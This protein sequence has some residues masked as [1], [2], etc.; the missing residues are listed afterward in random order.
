MFFNLVSEAF[1]MGA[2]PQAAD[3]AAGG[4]VQGMLVQ[5]APLAI[6]FVIFYFLLI[7][8]QQKKAKE[9]KRMLESLKKG[10]KIVTAGGIHG[11][12][13]SVDPGTVIVKIAETVKIKVNRNAVTVRTPEDDIKAE[14]EENE[15]TEKAVE[16]VK[17][18]EEKTKK[19]AKK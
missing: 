1:A 17:K 7:R 11:V 18:A 4:G 12:I 16:K 13:E 9:V 10:D 15:K 19:A 5:M 14:K 6:I 3:G 8:P 2:A